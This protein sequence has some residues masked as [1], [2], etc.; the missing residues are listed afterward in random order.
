MNVEQ[1]FSELGW[2]HFPPSGGDRGARALFSLRV[3]GEGVTNCQCN[4]KLSLH[5]T[6]YDEVIGSYHLRSVEFDIQ[7]ETADGRWVKLKAYSIDPDEL[8][9]AIVDD[10]KARLMRAWEAVQP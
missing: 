4:D 6:W 2:R 8:T 9:P 10:I 1:F 5:A 7:G 3:D